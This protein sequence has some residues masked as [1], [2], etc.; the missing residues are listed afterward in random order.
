MTCSIVLD[1]EH[2]YTVEPV[3]AKVTFNDLELFHGVLKGQ[4]TR[5]QFDMPSNRD[6]NTLRVHMLNRP[7]DGGTEV[8]T[9]GTI[10]RDTFVNV[11]SV[12]VDKRKLKYMI[13]DRGL[14][15]TNDGST[16]KYSTYLSRNGYYEIAFA[17][18]IK[19]VLQEYYSTFSYTNDRDVQK[20]IAEIDELLLDFEEETC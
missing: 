3:Q 1:L 10:L 8:D 4:Q 5:L 18:P 15:K 11:K 12:I 13:F 7:D 14:I 16:I 17:L 6:L 20:D 2:D 9:A 19:K